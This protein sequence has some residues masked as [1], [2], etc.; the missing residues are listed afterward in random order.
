MKLITYLHLV[1]ISI[2]QLHHTR[3]NGV[4][5]TRRDNFNLTKENCRR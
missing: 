5:I 3:F 4:T 2:M 1:S